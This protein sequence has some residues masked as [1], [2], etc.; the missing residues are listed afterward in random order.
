MLPSAQNS[1][2]A[3]I[4]SS[5]KGNKIPKFILIIFCVVISMFLLELGYLIKNYGISSLV[6]QGKIA[7]YDTRLWKYYLSTRKLTSDNVMN[8]AKSDCYEAKTSQYRENLPS[9][10]F[11]YTEGL[12]QKVLSTM[13]ITPE[14]TIGLLFV[15][16]EVPNT[17]KCWLVWAVDLKGRGVVGYEDKSGKMQL[18][19]SSLPKD[20]LDG[21]LKNIKIPI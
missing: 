8:L 4:E 14:K 13:G 9:N 6:P 15:Y 11:T 21:V 12:R 10:Y 16:S 19:S 3:I 7:G 5:Q 1:Q 20:Q 18:Y 2:N 17:N